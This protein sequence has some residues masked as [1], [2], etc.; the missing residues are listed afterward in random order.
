[1]LDAKAV[2]DS[3]ESYM[4][5]LK[6]YA[7][8]TST[9]I[10]KECLLEQEQVKGSAADWKGQQG[11][12]DRAN[13]KEATPLQDGNGNGELRESTAR[14]AL[15]YHYMEAKRRHSHLLNDGVKGWLQGLGLSKY[16]EQFEEHEVDQEVLPL[17]TFDDLKEMGV[18]AVGSRRKLFDA[19]QQ[20]ARSLMLKADQPPAFGP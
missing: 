10:S 20:L 5:R 18:M 11:S 14:C 12:S 9:R 16:A 2:S 13:N 4:D 15:A 7:E 6:P 19:I 17:L 8:D 1:L 3:G